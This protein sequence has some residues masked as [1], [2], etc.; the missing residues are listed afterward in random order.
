ML[1]FYVVVAMCYSFFFHF[2]GGGVE[3]KAVGRPIV[4]ATVYNDK[5]SLYPIL[6]FAADGSSNNQ[7]C[8]NTKMKFNGLPSAVMSPPAV[9]LTFD[10]DPKT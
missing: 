2:R 7:R 6:Y 8:R 9:T 3:W 1:H 4:H 5:C 10:L